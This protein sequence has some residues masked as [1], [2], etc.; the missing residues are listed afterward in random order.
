MSLMLQ[1]LQTLDQNMGITNMLITNMVQDQE[2]GHT[3][4]TEQ[5]TT[6]SAQGQGHIQGDI[7]KE[8]ILI[9]DQEAV[10]T[11]NTLGP[12]QDHHI[13]KDHH[14]TPE[15]EAEIPHQP[16]LVTTK[17]TLQNAMVMVEVIADHHQDTEVEE[18]EEGN[19][20]ILHQCQ[21]EEDM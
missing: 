8:N 19:T 14:D 13:I 15:A 11:T 4:L 17:I 21:T 16:I 2:V 9:Q 3:I 10:V 7:A 18:E 12:D 6:E 1:D 20:R 5:N